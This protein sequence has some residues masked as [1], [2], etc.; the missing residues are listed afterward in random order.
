MLDNL[1]LGRVLVQEN[2]R[3]FCLLNIE[4]TEATCW[5]LFKGVFHSVE[6]KQQKGKGFKLTL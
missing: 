6:G 1:L 2:K 3:F 4:V 5:I